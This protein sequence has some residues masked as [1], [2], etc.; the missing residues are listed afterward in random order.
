MLFSIGRGGRQE[1]QHKRPHH[2]MRQH[3]HEALPPL[4]LARRK[5]RRHC[6]A[7]HALLL[8]QKKKGYLSSADLTL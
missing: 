1:L 6:L 2:D 7:P 4:A 8:E 3:L 5:G